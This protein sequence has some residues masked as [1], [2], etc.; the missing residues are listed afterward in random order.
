VYKPIPIGLWALDYNLLTLFTHHSIICTTLVCKDGVTWGPKEALASAGSKKKKKKKRSRLIGPY[1]YNFW[2]LST[3]ILS[4]KKTIKIIQ[5]KSQQNNLVIFN[6]I[7]KII[8]TTNQANNKSQTLKQI[9]QCFNLLNS[10]KKI[11][12]IKVL[13]LRWLAR[14]NK[15][16][17]KKRKRELKVSCPNTIEERERGCGLKK[18][19][20]QGGRRN[21]CNTTAHQTAFA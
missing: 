17:K 6:K 16:K 20:T 19:R 8:P 3:K 9:K 5:P 11:Y 18:H 10:K 15:R 7:T 1:S 21:Q 13:G 14:P 12:K 2:A 4:K